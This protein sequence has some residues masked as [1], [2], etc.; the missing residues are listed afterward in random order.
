MIQNLFLSSQHPPLLL[1]SIVFAS[2]SVVCCSFIRV[3]HKIIFGQFSNTTFRGLISL[4][5]DMY[6]VW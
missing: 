5:T 2:M 3:C 6:L 4:A 1:L